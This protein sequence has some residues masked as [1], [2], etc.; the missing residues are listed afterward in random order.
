MTSEFNNKRWEDLNALVDGELDPPQLAEV[1]AWIADDPNAAKSF[2]TVA[3]LKA[4]ISSVEQ[5]HP[6]TPSRRHRLKSAAAVL[7]AVGLG[8]LLVY[9]LQGSV[10]PTAD[11]GRFAP[12]TMGLA[13]DIAIGDLRLPNLE[14][15][16]LR[17]DS[18]TVSREHLGARLEAIYLGERGCRVSLT[19]ARAANGDRVPTDNSLQFSRWKAG[20]FTYTM[21][22]ERMDPRRFAAVAEIA[23][24]DTGTPVSTQLAS[25]SSDL[26]N[27]PCLG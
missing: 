19:I 5:R 14:K 3:A 22:S 11:I 23:Q 9:A 10:S 16:G 7:L 6:A 15:G 18:V 27:R 13:D 21:T 17:L 24:A 25:R 1:A 8:G 12:K 20:S 4:A 2:A 26:N